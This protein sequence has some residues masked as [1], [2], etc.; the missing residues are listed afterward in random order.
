MNEELLTQLLKS[1]ESEQIERKA[2]LSDTD[3]IRDSFIQFANDINNRG[4]GWV[5]VGQA[6]DKSMVGTAAMITG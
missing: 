4:I 6:P 5:I 2:S 1:E 3:A